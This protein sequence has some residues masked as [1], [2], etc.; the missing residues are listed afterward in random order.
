MYA[1]SGSD[2]EVSGRIITPD[3]KGVAGTRVIFIPTGYNPAFDYLP[4]A[5]TI[6][7][8]DSN[9][10]YK[11]NV[12]SSGTYNLQAVNLSS[13]GRLLRSGITV[14][15]GAVSVSI[16]P[17]SL[18]KPAVLV[19]AVADSLFPLSGFAYASGTTLYKRKNAGEQ[20]VTFDSVPQCTL[21]QI[22]FKTSAGDPAVLLGSDVFIGPADT[23]FLNPFPGWLHAAKIRI[24]TTR[25]GILVPT[26]V[27]DFSAALRL[28]PANFPF[29]QAQAAGRDIRIA[30]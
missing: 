30:D 19:I 28:S 5:G 11:F 26:T 22:Q 21:K 2:T 23:T 29:A 3:G 20:S 13:G 14:P 12:V 1:G 27:T 16:G 15:S 18:K 8:T 24:N 6:D 9:G 7:T 17:D 25:T 4:D 10:V